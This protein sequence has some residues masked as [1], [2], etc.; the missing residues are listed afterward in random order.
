M[1][2]QLSKKRTKELETITTPMIMVLSGIQP[3]DPVLADKWFEILAWRS[4]HDHESLTTLKSKV[5]KL[6]SFFGFSQNYHVN[7]EYRNA[8]WGFALNGAEFVVYESNGGLAVQIAPDS[9]EKVG[10]IIDYLYATL[11]ESG[12]ENLIRK[13]REVLP[14]I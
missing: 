2:K 14:K 6:S 9:K 8:V 12:D 11:V 7:Y 10:E 13:T 3:N 5:R 1:I 4:M